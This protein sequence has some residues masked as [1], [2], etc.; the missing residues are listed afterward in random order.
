MAT[1]TSTGA[2]FPLGLTD[3]GTGGTSAGTARTALGVVPTEGIQQ[4]GSNIKLDISSLTEDVTP[5][6]ATDYVVTYDASAG[7]HK[8]VLITNLPAGVATVNLGLTTLIAKGMF[9]T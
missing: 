6:S 4:T 2:Q 9:S 1:Q 5:V 3:G 8:K 7:A